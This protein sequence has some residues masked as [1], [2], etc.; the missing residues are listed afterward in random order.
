M[1]DRTC[2]W[3]PEH[4]ADGTP[5]GER[6]GAPATYRIS[7]LDGTRRYSFACRDHLYLDPIAPI[8]L[9]EALEPGPAREP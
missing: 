6:C 8:P 4:T 9:I 2:D 3:C 5:L 1:S 7:W